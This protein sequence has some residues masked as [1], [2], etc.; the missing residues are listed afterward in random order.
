VSLTLKRRQEGQPP[1]TIESAWRA[2]IR[3]HRHWT[4]LDA[5]R[6]KKRTT[7]AVADE[8]R[9]LACF[10]WEIAQMGLAIRPRAPTRGWRARF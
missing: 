7:V 6:A 3:L 2:Q 5:G 10:V 1:D 8:A 4:H 9:E